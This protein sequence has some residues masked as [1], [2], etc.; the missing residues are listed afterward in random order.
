MK[1]RVF[2]AFL[3]W[4]FMEKKICKRAATV[5]FWDGYAPWYKLWM[6]HNNYHNRIIEVLTTMVEPGWKVLDVGAGSGILSSPLCAIGCDVTALEPSAGIRSLLYE[7]TF[8]RGIDWITVDDRRWE[9]VPTFEFKDYDLVMACN[10]LHLTEM[11]FADAIKKIFRVRP[12]N[13]FVITELG[14]PE[15]KV[16]WRDGDYSMLFAKCYETESF[17]AYHSMDEVF[18]H[19]AFKKGRPLC[20]DEKVDIKSR[21]TFEDNHLWIKDTAYVGMYWWGRKYGVCS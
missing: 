2:M 11:G 7:E 13:V 9:D 5:Q 3:F 12:R 10:S 15:I 4:R 8:K 16:K 1:V 17:F 18:E 21:L 6:E 14:P 20:P 19:W